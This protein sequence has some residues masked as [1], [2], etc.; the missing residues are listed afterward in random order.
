MRK[1]TFTLLAFILSLMASCLPTANT[2]EEYDAMSAEE[3]ALILFSDLTAA[4]FIENTQDTAFIYNGNS[5][6]GRIKLSGY[7][8]SQHY[9]I[10]IA[11]MRLA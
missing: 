6:E 8:I 7:G 3:A 10:G 1:I 9:L 2:P 4:E 11:Y 5:I